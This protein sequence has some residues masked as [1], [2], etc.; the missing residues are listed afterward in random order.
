[1]PNVLGH[2]LRKYGI[3]NRGAL[4][5]FHLTV[6]PIRIFVS[7]HNFHPANVA[8]FKVDAMKIGDLVQGFEH[9]NPDFN[10][11]ALATLDQCIF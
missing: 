2:Y 6:K 10:V 11:N 1:M 4:G 5:V 9:G 7:F 3:C 8:Y